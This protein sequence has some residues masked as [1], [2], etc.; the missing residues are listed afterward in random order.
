MSL[1]WKAFALPLTR[2]VQPALWRCML[3]FEASRTVDCDLA[4]V[5]GVN[6]M[7][8]ATIS[9]AYALAGMTSATGRCHT[10][11]AAADGYVRGEGCGAVVLKRMNDAISDHDRV[12]AVVRGVGV[13]QGRHERKFDSAEWPC[14]GKSCCA[15]PLRMQT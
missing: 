15:R 10:F 11:D 5:S 7:L 13:A 14:T 2:H 6:A 12:H 1:D 9:E 4:L 8:T 3:Q